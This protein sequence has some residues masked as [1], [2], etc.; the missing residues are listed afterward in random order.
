[1]FRLRQPSGLGMHRTTGVNDRTAKAGGFALVRQRLVPPSSHPQA[2]TRRF[3]A[4]LMAIVSA[5][6]TSAGLGSQVSC[7]IG[8]QSREAC[9]SPRTTCGAP[10]APRERDAGTDLA[11]VQKI[12]GRES[13]TTTGYDW[14]GDAARGKAAERVHVPFFPPQA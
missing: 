11:T 10:V 8:H 13:V 2:G 6:I 12:V 4:A 14:R 9:Y 7:A 3:T 5:W 1:M